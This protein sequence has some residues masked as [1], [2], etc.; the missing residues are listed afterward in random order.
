MRVGEGGGQTDVKVG[1]LAP[2]LEATAT[3]RH[4]STWGGGRL[5]GTLAHGGGWGVQLIGGDWWVC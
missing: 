4:A 5:M 3:G 1:V 2:R